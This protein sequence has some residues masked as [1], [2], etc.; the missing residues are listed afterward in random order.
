MSIICLET[1]QEET[2]SAML[3]DWLE[4]VIQDPSPLA[5]KA[6]R[7]LWDNESWE[8][9]QRKFQTEGSV[10]YVWWMD[11]VRAYMAIDQ[12]PISQPTA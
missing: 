2:Y 4:E 11:G 7:S 5:I 9:I 1:P 3:A 8:S 6:L 10:W 12:T